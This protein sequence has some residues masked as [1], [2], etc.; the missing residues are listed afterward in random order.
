MSIGAGARRGRTAAGRAGVGEGDHRSRRIT[1]IPRSAPR[2]PFAGLL[3]RLTARP[4][5]VV[6][7]RPDRGRRPGASPLGRARGSP[8]VGCL[9]NDL[10]VDRP[11]WG[12]ALA[13]RSRADAPRTSTPGGVGERPHLRRGAPQ[14]PSRRR[15]VGRGVRGPR[16][17]R[18][19]RGTG[20]TRGTRGTR[21]TPRGP[22]DRSDRGA[23]GSRRR[24]RAPHCA[25]STTTIG[26][27]SRR[28]RTR[29]RHGRQQTSQ[30]SIISPRCIG[31]RV[32]STRSRQ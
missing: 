16:G 4:G 11:P 30:S 23:R 13:P 8:R 19:T 15:R 9:Y 18:G 6:G 32:S 21:G 10:G 29:I 12:I 27:P 5:W 7:C 17:S 3:G 31:S 25:R 2:P 22:G 24:R 26:W 14:G 20:G 28:R 1:L